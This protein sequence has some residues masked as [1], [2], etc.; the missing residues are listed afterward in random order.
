MVCNFKLVLQLES[1][2]K[3][4]FNVLEEILRGW[5]KKEEERKTEKQTRSKINEMKRQNNREKC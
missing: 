4:I 3:F 1:L 5:S 2:Q